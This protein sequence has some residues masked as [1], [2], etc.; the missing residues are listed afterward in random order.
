MVDMGNPLPTN[1]EEASQQEMKFLALDRCHH[2]L[3]YRSQSLHH[4]FYENY[5][6]DLQNCGD[7]AALSDLYIKVNDEN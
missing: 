7:R 6:E 5:S 2:R 1:L 4:F 3:G